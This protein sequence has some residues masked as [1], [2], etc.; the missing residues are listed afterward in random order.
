MDITP[1]ILDLAGV[2]HPGKQWHGKPG[3]AAARHGWVF[4]WRD[5]AGA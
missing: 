2:R 1:T 4:V 5:G 3:G